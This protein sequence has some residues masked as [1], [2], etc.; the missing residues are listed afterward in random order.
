MED[1]LSGRLCSVDGGPSL[2]SVNLVVLCFS[3]DDPVPN[4]FS[5]GFV[6]SAF[7]ATEFVDEVGFGAL[8]G[9]VDLDPPDLSAIKFLH[10]TSVLNFLNAAPEN[11][12]I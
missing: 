11:F 12:S 4:L 10:S 9:N 2:G 7:R 3:V 6:S 1:R 8:S 5:S